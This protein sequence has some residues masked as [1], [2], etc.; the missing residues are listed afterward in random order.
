MRALATLGKMVSNRYAYPWVRADVMIVLVFIHHVLAT[1]TACEKTS[2]GG[3]RDSSKKFGPLKAA[4][5]AIL[6]CYAD[7]KVR[8][9][10]LAQNS[11]RQTLFQ[12]PVAAGNKI[13]NLLWRI[14]ALEEQFDSRP[15][16]VA[17]QRR[18]GELIGYV[19]L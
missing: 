6:N 14:N 4:L 19:M 13:G 8:L 15:T 7:H 11:L 3:A 12:E 1:T 18:R 17:E 10:P 16:D 5:G 9:H 2:P